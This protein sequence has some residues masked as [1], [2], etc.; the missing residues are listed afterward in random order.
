M[1]IHRHRHR[2]IKIPSIDCRW[3]RRGDF[4]KV[5]FIHARRFGIGQNSHCLYYALHVVLFRNC[6]FV[7]TNMLFAIEY[8]LSSLMQIYCYYLFVDCRVQLSETTK[9]IATLINVGISGI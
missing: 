8:R 5:I 7:S 3:H 6:I 2:L 4:V 9:V 1:N